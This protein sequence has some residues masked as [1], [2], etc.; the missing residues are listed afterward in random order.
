MTIAVTGST[1]AL[2]GLVAKMLAVRG[3]AQRLVVRDPDRAPRL[4]GATA[5]VASYDDPVAA[6]EAL[7]GVQTLFMV[8]AKESPH[9]L[10]DHR[11]FVE[12]AR[13]ARVRH[14]VYTSFAAAA[15]DATFTFARDH[16]AT[17]TELKA[18]GMGYTIL[19]DNF[20]MDVLPYFP[21]PDGVIRGPARSGTAAVVARADVAASAASV[22]LEPGGHAGR[23][24][25]LTGPEAMSL[26][27]VA[28][29]LSAATGRLITFH[30]ETV[31]EAYRSRAHYGAEPWEMDAWV[32]TYTAIAAGEMSTVTD[33]VRT[34]T[35]H[36]PRTLAGF[37]AEG[38]PPVAE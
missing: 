33:D 38:W 1:G 23:T 25:E 13:R 20:Y 8:S 22:M 19:R 37:L 26:S 10:A 12:A 5:A 30:D 11:T 31:D 18:S 29:A 6:A 3:I 35:G 14:I 24:Y 34:L 17:E 4:D 21:G 9:R 2:G 28:R 7:Q 32:S 15:P 27:V 36:P 16:F